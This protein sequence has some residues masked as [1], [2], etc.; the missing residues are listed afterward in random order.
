MM[1]IYICVCVYMFMFIMYGYVGLT[2]ILPCY[3]D[4]EIKSTDGSAE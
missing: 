4:S 2:T 1:Y 3:S